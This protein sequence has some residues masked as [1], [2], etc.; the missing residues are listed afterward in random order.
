[1]LTA[2][3]LLATQQQT[4]YSEFQPNPQ[5]TPGAVNPAL[6]DDVLRSPG[7]TTKDYRD[8][9]ESIK[10][11][12]YAEYHMDPK[13]APCPCEVDHFLSLEIGGSNDITNLWPQPY[14]GK[15]NA[16]DKDKL[17]DLLGANVRKGLMSGADARLEMTSGWVNS[18]IKHFGGK[19]K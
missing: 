17:E 4:N 9:P 1:M 19:Y 11:Q 14:S 6:T 16:H 18:Y 2:C 8:V 13:K 3:V 5:L 12:V 10:K 7:F 15:W